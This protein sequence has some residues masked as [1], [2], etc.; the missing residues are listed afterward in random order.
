[1]NNSLLRAEKFLG[2]LDIKTMRS[3]CM[4]MVNKAIL[5]YDDKAAILSQLK[6]KC[7]S[8]NLFWD[9]INETQEWLYLGAM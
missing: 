3:G 9:D 4:L 7:C 8:N 5:D 1:M 2:E 6:A